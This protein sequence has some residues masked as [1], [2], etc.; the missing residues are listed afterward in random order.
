MCHVSFA[1]W[2]MKEGREPF[3]NIVV[4]GAKLTSVLVPKE[5]SLLVCWEVGEAS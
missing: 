2:L 4:S 5:K 1:S 3:Q